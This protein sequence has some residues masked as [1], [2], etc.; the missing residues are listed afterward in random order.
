MKKRLLALFMAA[1]MSMALIACGGSE[2]EA[3]TNEAVTEETAEETVE[4]TTEEATEE[5]AG[6][7]TEEQAAFV[8]E[9]NTMVDDYNVMIDAINANEELSANE[10]LV[11][12]MNELTTAIDEC[13]EICEDPAN[14]TDEV[15]EQYRTAFA[16]T[17]DVI[18]QMKPYLS[19]DATGMSEEEAAM[20][21]VLT[22]AVAGTDE[23]E[24]TYFFLF[25]DDVTFGAFVIL[26]ADQ[27]QSLNV[28][29]EIT[30]TE[31]GGIK[32]IDEERQEYIAFTVVEE[33]EDYLV[34][35]VEE[36]NDVTLVGYDIDEA[37]EVVLAIDEV[38]EIVN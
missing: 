17:Y 24:N 6:D 16:Q 10:E 23:A 27:T 4:E 32:V 19:E 8:D 11:N 7:Y 3:A 18:E 22:T 1:T 9:F 36:G 21:A 25:N 15:M 29:G 2:E 35:S 37:I 31:E 20:K 13:A 33:G 12:M 14:L 34:V 30:E 26:S 28:V 5:L 38:T